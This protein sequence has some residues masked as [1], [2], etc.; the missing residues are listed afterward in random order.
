M[1]SPLPRVRL[2][3]IAFGRVEAASSPRASDRP[4][5]R[6]R[7]ACSARSRPARARS[8]RADVPRGQDH[9]DRP[10]LAASSVAAGSRGR[11]SCARPATRCGA[12]RRRGPRGARP[13]RRPDVVTRTAASRSIGTPCGAGALEALVLQRGP[14]LEPPTR[15]YVAAVTPIDAPENWWCS[16]A[17]APRG[18][19]R[20]R[21]RGLVA[22]RE[23]SRPG[24]VVR[25]RSRSRRRS[26]AR[27][28]RP[29]RAASRS[30]S[31][32]AAE[33]AS[34]VA[35]R[36]SGGGRRSAARS[37]P[38]GARGRR[39]APRVD[40][41]EPRGRPRRR[42]RRGAVASVQRSSTTT[43]SYPRARRRA[44]AAS[45]RDAALDQLLLVA[46]RDDDDGPQDGHGSGAPRSTSVAAALVVLV[47]ARG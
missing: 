5:S 45:A 11:R 19:A 14:R 3:S 31:R 39:P 36:P 6:R 1:A 27:P 40:D 13:I 4:G 25:R 23:R 47:A 43:I 29:R 22:A 44:G 15:A 2:C 10:P 24:S 34:V 37:I 17:P 42:A 20:R 32:R 26:P 33:S 9:A 7:A 38:A 21:V 41:R 46:R 16:R 18:V 30:Q 12:G 28:R 35:I 8:V